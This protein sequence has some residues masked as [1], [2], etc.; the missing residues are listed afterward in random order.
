MHF[1]FQSPETSVFLVCSANKTTEKPL[2]GV[3]LHTLLMFDKNT[4]VG[5]TATLKLESCLLNI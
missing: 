3:Y 5:D 1:I 2:T 4:L